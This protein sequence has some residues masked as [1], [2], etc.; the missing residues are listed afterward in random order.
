MNRRRI[1]VAFLLVFLTGLYP[2]CQKPERNNPWDGKNAQN[3]QEWAPQNLQI[4]PLSPIARKLSWEFG[5]L[6][7][8]GFKI[9][10]KKGEEPWQEAYATLPKTA[11][12]WIDDQIV[13]DPALVY[14]YRVYAFA[15]GNISGKPAIT[16][17]AAIPAPDNIQI[18]THS[19]TSITLS[20]NYNFTGH[21]GFMIDRKAGDEPWVIGLAILNPDQTSFHD[22]TVN[23]E[24]KSYSFKVYSFYEKYHSPKTEVAQQLIHIGS[25][26]FGGIV[27]YF[28]GSGGGMVCAQY[29]Q[30]TG[31]EWGCYG[32]SIGGTGTALGTGAANTAKIVA[33]CS[34]AGI[35]ARICNDLVLNGYSDWFLPSKD[36]LN[37]MYQNLKQ[38]GLGGV[39]DPWYWSS[40]E[41][42]SGFAWVQDFYNGSQDDTNKNYNFR[43]RAVRAF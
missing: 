24:S 14:Q 6:S 18:A 2:A 9:D 15:G 16:A 40:S 11:R 29:G 34:Q 32:T 10:R 33:G 30:S 38:A 27:F 26:S 36:E 22:N 1:F 4:T 5:T 35:A 19:T 28:N 23:L 12:E 42:S 37:L 3:P 8:E 17:S 13:H 7:I 20:W 31:T 41:D 43:V 25:F 39:V 21:D